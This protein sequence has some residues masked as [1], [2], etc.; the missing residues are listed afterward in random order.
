VVWRWDSDA[1][2][3][4]AA[5]LDPD[6]D[7][8]QLNVRLRFP[9]QYLDEET[10]LAYNYFRDYD[11]RTGRYVESDPIGL[12]GGLNSYLYAHDNSL[13]H[14]DSW[15]LWSLSVGAYMGVG[16]TL[17]VSYSNGTVELTGKLGLGWG[18]G[19]TLD[20]LGG[21]SPQAASS[22]SGYIYRTSLEIGASVGAGEYAIGGSFKGATPNLFGDDP[23]GPNY[24]ELSLTG[25]GLG[26]QSGVHGEI[27][28]GFEIGS[29]FQWPWARRNQTSTTELCR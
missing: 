25:V 5:N 12:R 16:A 17:N 7:T 22:G 15:G 2:G 8:V 28:A 23:N 24:H 10:G 20:P 6:G 9:G 26:P 3:V 19:A 27:S 11:P 18:G 14:Y 21:P 13:R 1:F 29:Y 4:G